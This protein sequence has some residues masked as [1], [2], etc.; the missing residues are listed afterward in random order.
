MVPGSGTVAALTWTAPSF[1]A[2]SRLVAFRPTSSLPTPKVN[3]L[4]P[5]A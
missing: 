2:N 3:R 5:A 4:V 1:L